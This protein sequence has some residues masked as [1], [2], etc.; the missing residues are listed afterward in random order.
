MILNNAKSTFLSESKREGQLCCDFQEIDKNKIII[1]EQLENVDWKSELCLEH[2]S[3]NLSSELLISKVDRLI[4]FWASLQKIPYKRKKA[5]N[6]PWMTKGIIKSIR[7]KNRLHKKICHL[8]DPLKKRELE[9]KF[10]NYKKI[11]LKLMQNSNSNHFNNYF[12]ENK[13]NLFKTGRVLKK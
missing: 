8:K 9:I 12:H 4:N 11:L 5:L 6:K 10:K 2:N 3:I 7:I 13:L 1:S